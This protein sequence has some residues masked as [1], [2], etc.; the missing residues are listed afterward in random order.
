MQLSYRNNYKEAWACIIHLSLSTFSL[1]I[2]VQSTR[3]LSDSQ[4]HDSGKATPKLYIWTF[5]QVEKNINFF[6]F[7][8]LI[9]RT[10]CKNTEAFPYTQMNSYNLSPLS[11]LCLPGTHLNIRQMKF[12]P[13]SAWVI[14]RPASL[15][16]LF[17]SVLEE[18]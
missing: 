2:P 8:G 4:K 11:L 14:L 7:L 3:R 15:Y 10:S 12:I 9:D 5:L 18:L 6:S 16:I 17:F 1:F 13:P